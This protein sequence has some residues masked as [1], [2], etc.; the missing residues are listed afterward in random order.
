MKI[1]KPSIH[2]LHLHLI[3]FLWGFT[4]VLGK[5]LNNLDTFQLVWYRVAIACTILAGII[6]YRKL[7]PITNGTK[8]TKQLFLKVFFTGF[9]VFLHWLCFYGAV[10]VSNVSVALASFSCTALFTGIFEPLILKRKLDPREIIL[11]VVIIA[12]MVFIFNAEIS[13]WKGMLLGVG[14]AAT[15]SLFTVINSTISNKVN[16]YYISFIELFSV[17]FFSTIYFLFFDLDHFPN[18]NLQGYDYIW[19][20][21]LSI[22]CTVYT[23]VASINL[24]KHVSPFTLSLTVNLEPV[25]AILFAFVLFK[26]YELLSTSFFI[27]TAMLIAV[28]LIYPVFKSKQ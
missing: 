25:Y 12:I 24:M 11:G 16:A 1:V 3:V 23:F 26:E 18:F 28:V 20:V 14:A 21:V 4:G 13:Y 15:A 7:T 19:I 22:L 6:I 8:F 5:L 27:G 2:I 10:K 17:L 9:I